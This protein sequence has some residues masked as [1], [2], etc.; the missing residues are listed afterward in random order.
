MKVK[1]GLK[2]VHVFPLTESTD[3]TTG[4]TSMT[5]AAAIAIPGAVNLSLDVS[6]SSPDPFYADD[7]IYYLPAGSSSGY[8]GNLEVAL[9]PDA[10]RIQLMAFVEDAANV[11]VEL[12][13]ATAKLFGMTFEIDSDTKA[14][15]FVYYKCQFSRPSLSASTN[16]DTKTPQTETAP[17]TVM[18]TTKTYTLGGSERAV[19]SAYTT[20]ETDATAYSTWHTTIHEPGA[21]QEP[22]EG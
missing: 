8:T 4:V 2:N 7:G 9:I 5:Y 1:F 21:T 16:T 17:I 13:E 6:E 22:G 10:V 11:I 18:P 3:T 15:K 19:V 14:R 20:E 12:K